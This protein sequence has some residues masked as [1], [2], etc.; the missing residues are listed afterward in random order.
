MASNSTV[1]FLFFVKL[2]KRA[3]V[4]LGMNEELSFA[5][6]CLVLVFDLSAFIIPSSRSR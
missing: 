5:L 2:L 3:T 4:L 1:V 6:V